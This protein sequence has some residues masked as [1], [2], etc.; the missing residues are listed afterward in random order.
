MTIEIERV[1]F[2]RPHMAV[3]NVAHYSA[4]IGGHIYD[5]I[6]NWECCPDVELE[7]CDNTAIMAFHSRAYELGIKDCN[8]II[9]PAEIKL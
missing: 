5:A 2:S 6:P 4:V 3:K 1:L 8:F 7:K 9:K